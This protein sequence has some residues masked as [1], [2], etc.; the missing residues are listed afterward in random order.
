MALM[1]R[2]LSESSAEMQTRMDGGSPALRIDEATFEAL[3]VPGD[4]SGEGRPRIVRWLDTWSGVG[5]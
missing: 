3:S 1:P 5:S 4:S 2:A